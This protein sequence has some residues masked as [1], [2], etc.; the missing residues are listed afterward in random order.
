MKIHAVLVVLLVTQVLAKKKKKTKLVTIPD[1]Y[2]GLTGGTCWAGEF[3]DEGVHC[4]P[5]GQPNLKVLTDG[6]ATSFMT[7]IEC[8][9]IGGNCWQHPNTLYN[10]GAPPVPD[11]R[12]ALLNLDRDTTGF[13]QAVLIRRHRNLLSCNAATGKCVDGCTREIA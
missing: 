12:R 13:V 11:V 8:C 4:D 2:N 3:D 10:D 9:E 5:D 1:P 6:A 7:Y